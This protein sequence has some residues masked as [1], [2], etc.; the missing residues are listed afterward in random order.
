MDDDCVMRS[1]REGL[2]ITGLRLLWLNNR[3]YSE[4]T[5]AGGLPS[6]SDMSST[7]GRDS[8]KISRVR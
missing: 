1:R 2:C 4:V 5:K 7:Q 8:R 3:I 6:S